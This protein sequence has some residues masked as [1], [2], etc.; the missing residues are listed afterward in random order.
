MNHL[1]VPSWL[2]TQINGLKHKLAYFRPV[3]VLPIYG[4]L[5]LQYYRMGDVLMVT[6]TYAGGSHYFP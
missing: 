2:L 5:I 6:L 1:L 3:P 4:D